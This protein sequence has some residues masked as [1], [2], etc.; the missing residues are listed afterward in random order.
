MEN[1]STIVL[2]EQQHQRKISF[3]FRKD[4]IQLTYETYLSRDELKDFL[5]F[6]NSGFEP[7]TFRIL[8]SSQELSAELST[9]GAAGIIS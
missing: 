9:T 2:H 8:D 5:N 7:G 1:T 3:R 4:S 6:L